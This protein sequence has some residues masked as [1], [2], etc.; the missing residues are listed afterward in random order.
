MDD[1]TPSTRDRLTMAAARRFQETGYHGTAIAD[2]LA[3]ARVPK[4]S[5]YHHFPAGKADLARAAADMASRVMLEIVAAAYGPAEDF[6]RGTDRLAEKFARLFERHPHWRS[7]PVQTFLIEGPMAGDTA[8]LLET[9]I[10]ATADQARRLRDADPDR[11][12]RRVWI[13]LIGCWTLA[14]AQ[15]DPAPLRALPDLLG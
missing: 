7:C 13:T 8:G 6:A 15:D 11:A 10:A 9:W 5:L 12:A 3:E 14:R 2:I 1:P 4:G